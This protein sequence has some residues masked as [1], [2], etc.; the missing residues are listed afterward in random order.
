M[1]EVAAEDCSRRKRG[2]GGEIFN[3]C[4]RAPVCMMQ[5]MYVSFFAQ[6]SDIDTNDFLSTEQAPASRPCF[7]PFEVAQLQPC[8][9]NSILGEAPSNQRS[10]VLFLHHNIMSDE[11][12]RYL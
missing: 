2:E 5:I 1:V 8:S 7:F 6:K 12:L 3:E 9:G 10:T 4:E 11:K